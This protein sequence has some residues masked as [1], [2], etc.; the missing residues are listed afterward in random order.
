MTHQLTPPRHSWRWGIL[1]PTVVGGILMLLALPTVSTGQ[2]NGTTEIA[3]VDS[4]GNRAEGNSEDSDISGNGRYVAFSSF[5]STL[6][7]GDTN[8]ERDVF[9][10]DTKTGA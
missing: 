8:E 6:V 10:H 4:A 2:S 3:S 5:A 1:L 9:V 7:P